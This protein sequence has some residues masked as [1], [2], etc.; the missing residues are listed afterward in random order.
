MFYAAAILGL[1]AAYVVGGFLLKLYTHFDTM[2]TSA[3][4]HC[5]LVIYIRSIFHFLSLVNTYTPYKL[6]FRHIL[7]RLYFLFYQHTDRACSR[8]FKLYRVRQKSS[9]LKFFA[10]F[11]ATV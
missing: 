7:K 2:D 5:V 1:V 6:T 8:L 3:S 10:V 9:P 11:S 4:V